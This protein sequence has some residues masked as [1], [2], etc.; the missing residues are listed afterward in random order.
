MVRIMMTEKPDYGNWVPIKYIY[1]P[2]VMGL[3]FVVLSYFYFPIF[4]LA[5]LGLIITIYMSYARAEFSPEG[6]DIQSKIRELVLKELKWNG[7]GKIIDIGAE[8][9]L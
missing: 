6:E 7:Q 8:M 5:V 1:I 9:P 2:G 4:I 3:L